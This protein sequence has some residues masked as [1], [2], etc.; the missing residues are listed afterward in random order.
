[1]TMT[2]TINIKNKKS[3]YKSP[4]LRDIKKVATLI[5]GMTVVDL[6]ILANILIDNENKYGNYNG[7]GLFQAMKN[8]HPELWDR[9]KGV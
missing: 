2:I 1:M 5:K 8:K 9:Y 6:H 3:N 4:S 7:Q